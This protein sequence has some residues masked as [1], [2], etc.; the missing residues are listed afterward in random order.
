MIAWRV[1]LVACGLAAATYGAALLAETGWAN[2]LRTLPW[3]VGGVLVHDALLAPATIVVMAIAT[4]LLPVWLRGPAAAGAVVIASVTI[5]AVPVLGRFGARSDNPTLLDRDYAAGW[6]GAAALTVA[7][8]AVGAA[9][10]RRALR[11][12]AVRVEGPGDER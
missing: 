10:R 1:G 2:I 6:L 5:L 11:R 9:L 7:C 12:A 8:V 3:L 4:R